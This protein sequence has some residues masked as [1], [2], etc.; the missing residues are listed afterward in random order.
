MVRIELALLV[1]AVPAV[2]CADEAGCTDDGC[3]LPLVAEFVTDPAM[4][5]LLSGDLE[6]PLVRILLIVE[7]M[8]RLDAEIVM[9]LDDS[10]VLSITVSEP[11]EVGSPTEF[12]ESDEASRLDEE[13]ELKPKA[14]V[15][16]ADT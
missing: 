4:L 10:A 6:L 16:A 1:V 15:D 9:L 7:A 11:I 14:E 5:L 12:E 8:D 3:E 13:I 2:L